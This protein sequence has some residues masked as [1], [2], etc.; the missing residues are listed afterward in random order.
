MAAVEAVSEIPDKIK[1]KLEQYERLFE[2][3]YTLKDSGFR[4]ASQMDET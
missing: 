1:K 2:Y 3:R 4:S